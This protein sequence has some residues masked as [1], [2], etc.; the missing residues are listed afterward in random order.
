M[1]ERALPGDGAN[2]PELFAPV[3]TGRMSGAIVE[4]VRDLIA[5]GHLKP[6]HRLPSER[7]LAERFKVSRVTVRDALRALETMGLVDIRVGAAGGAFVTA[8]STAIVGEGIRNMLMT[9]VISP[10]HVAEVRL[11]IEVGVVRLA[12]ARATEDDIERL[13]DVC[14][15]SEDALRADAYETALSTEF[16]TSLAHAA[17]NPAIEM[18]ADLFRGPLS[19]AGVRAMEPPSLSHEKSVHEHV[20]LLDAII[21][22]DLGEARRVMAKHLLRKTNLDESTFRMD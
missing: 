6:G 1:E 8:P 13:K 22:R 12:V 21:A 19:M 2:T 16:H 5:S 9:G 4:Q 15:R 10:E 11:L 14:A 18:V 20:A 3:E 7:E 17:H